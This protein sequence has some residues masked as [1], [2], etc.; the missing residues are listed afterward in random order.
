MTSAINSIGTC[1]KR[2]SIIETQHSRVAVS[3]KLVK[4]SIVSVGKLKNIE[5]F[6]EWTP[7][8]PKADH[9]RFHG[10]GFPPPIY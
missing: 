3:G 6:E 1:L 4:V 2:K 7:P 5:I 10:Y 9:V 8:A